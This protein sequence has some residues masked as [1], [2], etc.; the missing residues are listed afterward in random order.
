MAAILVSRPQI[1]RG[2]LVLVIFGLPENSQNPP[3]LSVVHHL[4][5]VDAARKWLGIVLRVTRFVGAEQVR[6]VGELFRAARD[7]AFEEPILFQERS[8]TL[9]VI[10]R[11]HYARSD[12]ARLTRSRGNQPGAGRE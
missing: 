2:Q 5:A 4:N 3:A 10:V 12:L 7:L 9:N 8:R 1:F 6:D 11:R